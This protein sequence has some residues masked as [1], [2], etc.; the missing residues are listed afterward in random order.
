MNLLTKVLAT[1]GCVSVLATAA[2][3]I[4]IIS[5][6]VASYRLDTAPPTLTISGS[7]FGQNPIVTLGTERLRLLSNSAIHLVAVASG[8]GVRPNLS[9]G[10]HIQ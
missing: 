8:V 7:G 1:L 10:G 5:S 2:H 3:A 4:P 6:V 9:A